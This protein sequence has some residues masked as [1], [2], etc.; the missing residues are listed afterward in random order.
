MSADNWEERARIAEVIASRWAQHD[1][2]CKKLSENWTFPEI[3]LAMQ[4]QWRAPGP[5][6]SCGLDKARQ[7]LR[8]TYA[9]EPAC[10]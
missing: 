10:T 1:P 2:T 4:F 3:W 6:C 8:D 9:T 5:E 7:Q